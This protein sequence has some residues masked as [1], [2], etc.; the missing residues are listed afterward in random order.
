MFDIIVESVLNEINA[1]DAYNKFYNFMDK[2]EFDQVVMANNGKFD[3][4]VRFLIDGIKENKICYQDACVILREYNN[5]DN[6]VRMAVKSKFDKG[7]YQKPTDIIKDIDFFVKNGVMT[8]KSVQ[9][10]GY[11][12][13]YDDDYEKLTY[14]TTYEANHHYYGH[15]QWCTASDRMG[16]YDGWIYF[17][18]YTT[19]MQ[20]IDEIK[21]RYLDGWLTSECAESALFQYIHKI[22]KKTYQIQISKSNLIKQI[23]DENDIS[24]SFD[25]LDMSKIVKD[26]MMQNVTNVVELTTQSIRKE[27]VYQ[28]SREES[29]K[30][31]RDTRRQKLYNQLKSYLDNKID[32]IRQSSDKIFN[33][34]LLTN[35]DF[36]NQLVKNEVS[37]REKDSYRNNENIMNEYE[38]KLKTQGY[39]NIEWAI[40]FENGFCALLVKPCYGL[41]KKINCDFNFENVFCNSMEYD[42]IDYFSSDDDDS[43]FYNILKGEKNFKSAIVLLNAN[44]TTYG[45]D[46]FVINDINRVINVIK[47][48]S[49]KSSLRSCSNFGERKTDDF[50][51]NIYTSYRAIPNII[52]YKD[53]DKTCL[54]SFINGKIFDISK[55]YGKD[56]NLGEE[57]FFLCGDKIALLVPQSDNYTQPIGLLFDSN[58]N[59]ERLLYW[60]K[61]QLEYSFINIGVYVACDQ[62]THEVFVISRN[63]L[64]DSGK[65]I[66][67]D[68]V[69]IEFEYERKIIRAEL[70]NGNFRVYTNRI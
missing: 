44:V 52:I 2:N 39:V 69:T 37:F 58:F 21:D 56:I 63:G 48:D 51:F 49:E 7:E 18:Y 50:A 25:N 1:D 15:T 60:R 42:P 8:N 23:C 5:A 67:N 29:L 59:V 61:A 32:F 33:S 65:K 12:I 36:V 66:E 13:L 35:V 41:V 38:Y 27:S 46:G 54:F 43:I 11:G 17:L 6:E 30:Q 4:L 31:K 14:T 40:G 68:N 24:Q 20:S 64:Y 26:T 22:D 55:Y 45:F 16:R 57:K 3:K 19:D 62:K 70:F 10:M 9:K 28:L 34:N 53:D 47:L